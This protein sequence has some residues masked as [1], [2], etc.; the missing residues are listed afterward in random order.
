MIIRAPHASPCDAGIGAIYKV[1]PSELS[2]LQGLAGLGYSNDPGALTV[3]ERMV[4]ADFF[5]TPIQVASIEFELT[6][7]VNSWESRRGNNT[8]YADAAYQR[9]PATAY[10]EL[11]SVADSVCRMHPVACQGVDVNGLIS[12]LVDHYAGWF[13][14][15]FPKGFGDAYNY[16]PDV[17]ATMFPGAVQTPNGGPILAPAPTT[18]TGGGN[19]TAY[20][21][22]ASLP[23]TNTTAATGGGN[24]TAA[25]NA[26]A[27]GTGAS[28]PVQVSLVNLTRSNMP[29]QVGDRWQLI[30]RGGAN[31][32]VTIFGLKDGAA[33]GSPT[34]F[35]S[36]D[37]TG[38]RVIDG[39]MTQNEVGSWRETVTVGTSSADISFVV[40]PAAGSA[41]T[42]VATTG[43]GNTTATGVTQPAGIPTTFPGAAPGSMPSWLPL[44]A[45]A[46]A[47]LYFFGGRR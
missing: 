27:T 3:N 47:L 23:L 43:G 14:M 22:P 28:G 46:A 29:L 11:K 42:S 31:L 5:G 38:V 18:S 39:L 24:V 19:T 16:A 33:V 26:G 25:P 36:T 40:S 45:G 34:P 2:G 20:S 37:A 1:T 8:G 7:L 44:V 13:R 6:Q 4:T 17:W 30:I 41:S 12:S 32:P 15:T 10:Q 21:V 9:D 35:G